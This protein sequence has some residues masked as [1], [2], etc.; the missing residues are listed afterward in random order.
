MLLVLAIGTCLGILPFAIFRSMAHDWNI[1]I[2]D[3]FIFAG[4]G[5]IFIFVYRTDN[6][7]AAS[8]I[9]ISLA[10]IGNVVSF[11]LKGISQ[12]TWIYPAMLSAYYVMSPK[13]G[14]LVNFIM[15]TFYIPKLISIL[16]VINVATI[17][18]TILI[19]NIIAYVFA[20]GLRKQETELKK[21]A[22]V[23][24]LTT[25]GNRRALDE[26]LLKLHKKLKNH[27]RT[28]SLILLDLDH[29]KKIN[30]SKG[31]IFGDDIL[32]KISKLLLDFFN[33]KKQVYRFGG[34]EFLVICINKNINETYEM[35][36]EF[37]EMVKNKIGVDNR[38]VTVSLGVTEY[39]KE[40]SSEDWI[41]RVDLALYQAKN[42][43][44]DRVVK[45]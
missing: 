12:I 45:M 16:E 17:L 15:L 43:G 33:R 36:E 11:Y 22:T 1:A 29:F 19:T 24:Y 9:L 6:V 27:D 37:R 28:A 21:L 8:L 42:Q 38:K 25:T 35:A 23:D 20:S 26:R 39:I 13:K 44:R 41:H 31:H 32:V 4:M 14:M 34:E 3:F 18:V 7:K 2:L 40:E 30:D 5:S 10:L